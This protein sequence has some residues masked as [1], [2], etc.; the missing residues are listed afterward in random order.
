MTG[1][2]SVVH[3]DGE[4]TVGDR[5]TYAWGARRRPFLHP[6]RTPAGHV[7]SRD[8][9][10]DHPWH[11]GLWFTIKYVDG[12]NFWEEEESY[13]VLRHQG[14]PAVAVG[15]DGTVAI[16]G[17]LH[18]IRPDRET[19]AIVEHRTFTHVPIAADAYAIDL[20]TTIVPAAATV[21]D[22]TPFQGWGGYGGF[23]LR[24]PGDL[25][26]P[27]LLLSDGSEHQQLLGTTGEWL[28]LA[29]VPAG[30]PAGTTAGLALF[31][32]PSNRRHP[33]PW[34]AS[35]K[36][37]LYFTDDWTNFANAAFLWD[38]PLELAAGEELRVRHRALVHDGT[39]TTDRLAKAWTT[40]ATT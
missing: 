11:H 34:Y 1:P 25:D 2:T 22:R 27:H 32:H 30:A 17:D 24:G 29:G 3:G 36:N 6:V 31:D 4:V 13:G 37:E 38:A 5:W 14:A 28:D 19:V 12:D 23:T 7:L 8:A 40:Y 18:W 35:T 39:W 10:P 26:Q 21:L 9:P 15:D 20:D 16:T 33:T